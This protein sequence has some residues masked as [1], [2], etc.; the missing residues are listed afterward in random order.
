MKIKI[1]HLL[2][3]DIFDIRIFTTNENYDAWFQSTKCEF[4]IKSDKN[5]GLVVKLDFGLIHA[6]EI[7][8]QTIK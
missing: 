3:Q 5:E 6:N 8:Y 7:N 1:T 2:S 4:D